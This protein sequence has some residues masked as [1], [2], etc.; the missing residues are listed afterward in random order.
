MLVIGYI[1]GTVTPGRNENF[2]AGFLVPSIGFLSSARRTR[3]SSSRSRGNWQPAPDATYDVSTD[4]N[5][6]S[7][8]ASIFTQMSAK[9]SLRGVE[10]I[11]PLNFF[12]IP[13]FDNSSVEP[14]ARNR[15]LSKHIAQSLWAIYDTDPDAAAANDPG[16]SKEDLFREWIARRD[17]ARAQETL[18]QSG[19]QISEADRDLGALTVDGPFIRPNGHEYKARVIA[20]RHQDVALLRHLHANKM[21]VR[22]Y[23][24]AGS[25]KTAMVEAAF[26][27]VITV[28]GNGDLTVSGLVGGLVPDGASW[29]WV[30]GPLT[31][32]M[33]E[34]KVL[35]VDEILR[36]P[37]EVLAILLGAMDGR[38]ILRLD[39]NPEAPMVHAEEGF[40]VIA[41]YNPDVT[42]GRAL[43][44]A[45]L[46]RFVVGIEV[47]T[48]FEVAAEL[49][50]PDKALRVARNLATCS[51]DDIERGGFGNW[52]PQMRDL[53]AFRDVLPLGEEFAVGALLSAC[54]NP[55]D[56]SLV[57][58]VVQTVFGFEASRLTAGG[59]A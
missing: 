41:A 6:A 31:R 45:I 57:A 59:R 32:A 24:P 29:R 14:S 35:F 8:L 40:G 4:E 50:V 25:G 26:P 21:P 44:E 19:A 54:P 1:A 34:G 33:K 5:T 2:V 37:N 27:D 23:G 3:A 39:D 7:A 58:E 12:E 52:V 36:I 38:G 9:T 48:D 55:E 30:D 20:G 49:G 53:L 47:T 10:V 28:L 13:E 15:E 42:G 11:M 22:L 17:R 16:Y 46:S 56:L 18:A 51:A 43:D